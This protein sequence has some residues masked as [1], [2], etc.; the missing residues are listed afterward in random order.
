MPITTVT[1][2][3]DNLEFSPQFPERYLYLMVYLLMCNG[4][5]LR[6]VRDLEPRSIDLQKRLLTITS[7]KSRM[8]RQVSIPPELH[9]ILAAYF[10]EQDRARLAA[11][12]RL[13]RLRRLRRLS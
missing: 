8:T 1:P 2:P 4:L 6:E 13:D 9:G 11:M 3:G 10:Q 12:K 5:R 7:R